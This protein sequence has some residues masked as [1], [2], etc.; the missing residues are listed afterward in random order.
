[1]KIGFDL[2]SDLNLTSEDDFNWEGKVTSLYCIIAG[3]LSNDLSVIVSTL[4]HLS[5]LYQGVFYT[6]GSLEYENSNDSEKRTKELVSICKQINNVTLLHYHVVIIDG[7]AILGCNGW[8]GNMNDSGLIQDA[9]IQVNRYE[10]LRYLKNSIDKLQKHLDVTK[11]IVVTNSV[12][13]PD[14][15]FGE[16][17]ESVDKN[18]PI[19]LVLFADTQNKISHWVFGKYKKIVDTTVNSINYLS[20]PKYNQNPYWAK[21]FEVEL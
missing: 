4:S 1:M 21:R 9:R 11:I 12:P 2:I 14:L 20:N 19:T 8:Y 10:D 6:L 17:P 5:K 18:V 13:S 3:N 7:V 15:Y 16:I